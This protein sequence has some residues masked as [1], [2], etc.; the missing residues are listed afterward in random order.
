MGARRAR[1]LLVVLIVL[2]LVP[3]W[4]TVDRAVPVSE[5]PEPQ[6]LATTESTRVPPIA[7]L[8][9]TYSS[10]TTDVEFAPNQILVNFD[11]ATPAARIESIGNVIGAEVTTRYRSP[12]LVTFVLP[13]DVSVEQAEEFFRQHDEVELIERDLIYYLNEFPDDPDFGELWGLHNTGQTGGVEDIDINAPEAWFEVQ[14]TGEFVIGVIDSGADLTHPDLV[15]T[16][17]VNPLEIPGNGIDDD[18]NGHVDDIHGIDQIGFDGEPNDQLDHG[19]HVG[20]T[21]AAVG[22]NSVG[23]VG[24]FW[25]GQVE[26]CKVFSEFGWT[27]LSRILT[28]M[29]YQ[30]WMKDAGINLVAVNASWGSYGYSQ[31]LADSILEMRDRDI[32]LVA[33]A[34]NDGVNTDVTPQYPAGYDFD[35]IIAVAAIDHAGDLP[36]WTNYGLNSVDIAAPGVNVLSTVRGGQWAYFDG[37]SMAAPHVAGVVGMIKASAPD[38][39]MSEVRDWVLNTA[40]PDARLTAAVATGGRLRIEL[41]FIDVDGDGMSD[42]WE[43]RWGLDPANSLDAAIDLDGDGLDNLT[44]YVNRTDP[45]TAD[46]DGDGLSDGEEVNTY[47][48]NP[49]DPDTDADGID[50]F[51]EVTTYGTNPNA[52]DT[53][54]DGLSDFDEINTTGTNAL[55][56]DTDGDGLLDGWELDN[57]YDPFDPVEGNQDLDGDGLTSLEEQAVFTDP[58]DPDTDDDAL[59]DRQEV[60]VY[61]TDPLDRD[62]DDDDLD[63]G[64]EVLYALDPHD[65]T[66]GTTDPDVDGY[67]SREEFRGGSSPI[68][69]ASL[70]H[71]KA[72]NGFLGDAQNSAY[73]PIHTDISLL[74]ERWT[75][76]LPVA[77]SNSRPVILD[78]QSLTYATGGSGAIQRVDAADGRMHWTTETVTDGT[79]PGFL[80]SAGG[81][82]YA[83]VSETS[84][85]QGY[86][87][88][89]RE[90][91]GSEAFPPVPLL[92]TSIGRMTAEGDSLFIQDQ[93]DIARIDASNGAEIWRTPI[94]SKDEYLDTPVVVRG[95]T[96]ATLGLRSLQT[97]DRETGLAISDIDIDNC[98]LHSGYQLVLPEDDYAIVNCGGF[99]TGVDLASEV[100]D[101][102]VWT[103]RDWSIAYDPV[104]VYV[105][106]WWGVHAIDA[107]SGDIVWTYEFEG[108]ESARNNILVTL[109]HVFVGDTFDTYALDISTGQKVWEH[110]LGGYVAMSHDGSLLI[111]PLYQ[112]NTR[113]LFDTTGD[114]DGDSMP[115]WWEKYHGLAF[116][117]PTDGALDVD[118]DGLTNAEEYALNTSPSETDTDGDGLSDYVEVSVHG[119]SPTNVDS[120]GDGLSDGDEVS[121]YASDPGQVD[122]DGDGYS[123]GDEVLVF[124]S[125]PTSSSSV[126]ALL[127]PYFE[128]FEAGLPSSWTNVPSA[129]GG[130]TV[131]SNEST[132]GQYSLQSS[133]IGLFDSAEIEFTENFRAGDIHFDL[134]IDS[135]E[136]AEL[137]VYVDDQFAGNFQTT[138][139]QRFRVYVPNG[140]HTIR[141]ELDA[142]SDSTI[143]YIDNL[144]YVRPLP[145][146]SNMDNVIAMMD[147]RLFELR[148]SGEQVRAAIPVP[149]IS[150]AT[151]LMMTD[152]RLLVIAG[153]PTMLFDTRLEKFMSINEA[154]G[155]ATPNATLNAFAPYDGGFVASGGGPLYRFNALGQFED[156]NFTGRSYSSMRRGK[157]GFLYGLYSYQGSV[158]RIDP[159]TLSVT[160]TV[161]LETWDTSG[162]DVNEDGDFFSLRALNYIDRLSPIGLIEETHRLRTDIRARDLELNDRGT[163]LLG[164]VE[165]TMHRLRADFAAESA[166]VLPRS[167]TGDDIRVAGVPRG[168]PDGD[169]DG[170]PDWWEIANALDPQDPVDA[171][172][173]S[174]GDGL[175]SVEEYAVN[176]DPA[177]P[178]TDGDGLSDGDETNLYASDATLVDTDVDG[179]GDYDEV[180][181]HGTSPVN[182]DTDGDG[183]TDGDELILIGSSPLAVDTDGDGLTDLFEFRNR[184]AVDDP[185]DGA[186]DADGDGLSNVEEFALGTDIGSADSDRDG[187]TDGEERA[188]WLTDPLQ[189]D[190]DNDRM[191]DGWETRQGLDPLVDDAALDADADTFT[192]VVEFYAGSAP[193]D[194]VSIPVPT[195][196]STDGGDIR[197]RGYLPV[198]L[199][200]NDFAFEWQTDAHDT[201]E[202]PMSQL[203]VSRDYVFGNI[204]DPNFNEPILVGFR[205]AD[206]NREW[207]HRFEDASIANPPATDTDSVYVQTGFHDNSY[208]YG[209]SQSDGSIRFQTPYPSQI[210]TARAPAIHGDSLFVPSGTFGGIG[211]FDRTTGDQIWQT[212]FSAGDGWSPTIIGDSIYAFEMNDGLLHDLDVET[213][214]ENAVDRDETWSWA[215]YTIY[216]SL[217]QGHYNNIIYGYGPGTASLGLDDRETQ[218][219]TPHETSYLLGTA[220]GP[221]VVYSVGDRTLFAFDER[222]GQEL[223]RWE[224]D[225][226]I[227][228]DPLVTVDHVFVTTDIETY[229][230]DVH[231]GASTWV[232]PQGGFL[233][234]SDDLD[235]YIGGYDGQLFAISTQ[236]DT[237]G[238]RIPDSW[239][240]QHGF[241]HLD[242][243]DATTDTDSDGLSLFDEYLARTDPRAG[244]TDADSLSDIAEIQTHGTDPLQADTD[245]DGLADFEEIGVLGSSPLRL[246]SDG[247]GFSDDHEV[248]VLGTSPV[249]TDS[250]GDGFSD[251][252]EVSQGSDPASAASR[253]A[254]VVEFF[255]S[256]E[257]GTMPREFVN[258]S[259]LNNNWLVGYWE[260]SH[261]H[262]VLRPEWTPAL[263][264]VEFTWD[265]NFAEG[266]LSF[267]V[268]QRGTFC[269]DDLELLIDGLVV[270]TISVEQDW[271]RYAYVVSEGR[272]EISWRFTRRVGNDINELET[273]IDSI[274]FEVADADGDGMPAD[275]EQQYGLD[276][277]DPS[278]A[279]LDPD[280]DQLTNLQEFQAGTS[281]LNA[282][283]DNDSMP[284]GW[285]VQ[286]SLDPTD[287][288]DRNIDSDSDALL[289]WEEYRAGTSPIDSD[290]DN[291]A[292]PD[293]WEV[294]N[295]LDPLTNDAAGDPDGDGANNLAEYQA[296]TDPQDPASAPSSG[297]GGSGGGGSGGGGS[298]GGGGGGG[299]GAVGFGDAWFLLLMLGLL[300]RSAYLSAAVAST[301]QHARI[302]DEA[303]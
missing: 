2:A 77:S 175:S 72:W 135:P 284:D 134:R 214:F 108:Q 191:T 14:D 107:R 280:S 99:L 243:S 294:S 65:A 148:P 296:G 169:G 287:A 264:S 89:L 92:G 293:G 29:D 143:G 188:V 64:W 156:S 196:W 151:E 295:N 290:T 215:G 43:V 247:D 267:D 131:L 100:V 238:D 22:N 18:G 9:P 32:I 205:R 103:A 136:P 38:M 187:L 90:V 56:A 118:S 166:L 37:T 94:R 51:D 1:T 239:E 231:T 262:R 189:P 67:S 181:V 172:A 5:A 4:L 104:Y 157:D 208:I 23:V 256:F 132:D 127:D 272:H 202:T 3:V 142:R 283:S 233:A 171:S 111:N 224:A 299:G 128:S 248:N 21:I 114:R 237:D 228:S 45:N 229:A 30:L 82:V 54:G 35:N 235:L 98:G 222:T 126:P 176:G 210:T 73:M 209:M 93:N 173:D 288:N 49:R 273:Y 122:T 101:W 117:D 178:D 179:V 167:L 146:G 164:G 31:L 279:T 285:E 7:T 66:D 123:D 298:S 69:P 24:V 220:V 57:G 211:R 301:R 165:F 155:G 253:P 52:A 50:D 124:G 226:W 204:R 152:D 221:G 88:A 260:G 102:Q 95:D 223:W 286:Y 53:D 139:W 291:D 200:P 180:S 78:R 302:A 190:S 12:G 275:W 194:A 257:S 170:M 198:R 16:L 154:T 41:P 245:G 40:V 185:A 17:W 121:I 244:D 168:G 6:I 119:T 129:D 110:T 201:F 10:P 140:L 217:I 184:L 249:L 186:A 161:Q 281:P 303:R 300:R 265:D 150:G 261:G 8:P 278:D 159:L 62:T 61:A 112:G 83:R 199:D 232:F 133:T 58:N 42:R 153:S 219:F 266:V 120:D 81:N 297:G 68:D 240:Q 216:S 255:E 160:N 125:D 292:M 270:D 192:N 274:R 27:T 289:N 162:F 85:W 207:Q 225:R 34:G 282:D 252:V 227:Q 241:D 86:L 91:D 147:G 48:S 218:W 258:G 271:T 20:G 138:D 174:D 109:D 242:A 25:R 212:N 106:S 47:A 259:N 11:D 183:L 197:H 193:N 44:E 268:F 113:I 80:Q 33:S 84:P 144:R 79:I 177:N 116:A 74:T 246:D 60:I 213:G 145:L 19:S 206:G 70:P 234:L 158:D 28:C 250:D 71:I 36:Y 55:V 230:I 251:D 137:R 39:T 276:P 15:D 13:D 96:V 269:C 76:Q 163:I 236:I 277:N 26:H 141:F 149:G 115:D 63:D 254:R 46:T 195:Q 203:S 263:D 182:A 87:V 130:F 59:D 105:G 97:F 75:T